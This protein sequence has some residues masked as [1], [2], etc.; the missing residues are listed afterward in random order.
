MHDPAHSVVNG[1][2]VSQCLH[3][4]LTPLS[5]LFLCNRVCAPLR[6]IVDVRACR[7]S[8]KKLAHEILRDTPPERD[9]WVGGG[10]TVDREAEK[11]RL[12]KVVSGAGKRCCIA[13]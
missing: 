6:L 11:D 13:S 10:P 9:M 4:S 7:F 3:R 5:T 2:L 1:T 8:G 12:S